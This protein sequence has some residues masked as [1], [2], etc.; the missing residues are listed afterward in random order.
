MRSRS[1]GSVKSKTQIGKP[2]DLAVEWSTAIVLK[3]HWC[4][5]FESLAEP[6]Q[7]SIINKS[8]KD[9]PWKL[10]AEVG[11]GWVWLFFISSGGP[12]WDTWVSPF[13][14]SSN[15][16]SISSSESV[17]P[18]KGCVQSALWQCSDGR[19]MA[20]P[21]P[22][23]SSF[24]I[25][26]HGSV[27]SKRQ[28]FLASLQTTAECPPLWQH[29]HRCKPRV[30]LGGLPVGT[31]KCCKAGSTRARRFRE[32]ANLLVARCTRMSNVLQARVSSLPVNGLKSTSSSLR[33][34]TKKPRI[35]S[36]CSR[37]VEEHLAAN[38]TTKKKQQKNQENTR[39]KTSKE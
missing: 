28:P 11:P 36:Y 18:C 14:V 4:A 3:P 22:P 29:A 6:A 38:N 1:S 19:P 13:G 24:R 33:S 12:I 34:S 21:E 23:W 35:S 16:E 20:P 30:H 25:F 10:F 5:T 9:I 7:I 37:S 2:Q 32:N 27:G 39:Q 26:S 8:S 15:S 31:A 17:V